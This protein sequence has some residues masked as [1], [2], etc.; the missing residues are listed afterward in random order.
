MHEFCFFVQ[1]VDHADD[2]CVDGSRVF[3][4]YAPQLGIRALPLAKKG[5][6]KDVP[7]PHKRLRDGKPRL[8]CPGKIG[9]LFSC[10]RKDELLFGLFYMGEPAVPVTYELMVVKFADWI[11]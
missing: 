10:P 11:R 8:L 5:H 9:E 7:V 1:Y 4:F 3:Q 6:D 2:R